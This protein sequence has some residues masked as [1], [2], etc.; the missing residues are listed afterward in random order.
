M[1]MASFVNCFYSAQLSHACREGDAACG[2]ITHMRALVRQGQYDK[3]TAE[4][5]VV[6]L[7]E[8]L[9]A[10]EHDVKS[11]KGELV[12]RQ[13]THEREIEQLQR[14]HKAEMVNLRKDHSIAMSNLHKESRA[15]LR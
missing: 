1:G 5:V 13:R 6:E 10:R 15:D 7:R 3:R 4:A 14:E 8:N 11:L 12:A 9:A 2:E